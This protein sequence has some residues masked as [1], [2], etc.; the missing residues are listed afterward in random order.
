M[1]WRCRW[2]WIDRAQQE[3]KS[4]RTHTR[5]SKETNKEMKRVREA[6]RGR[7]KQRIKMDIEI[8][9]IVCVWKL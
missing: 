5:A 1:T 6:E 4:A 9:R 3:Y 7:K 8:S 2:H